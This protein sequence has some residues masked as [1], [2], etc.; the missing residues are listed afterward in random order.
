MAN[1][2]SNSAQCAYCAASYWSVHLPL[3]NSFYKTEIDMKNRLTKK[4][5]CLRHASVVRNSRAS[6]TYDISIEQ[7]GR[8][9]DSFPRFRI[10]LNR[11]PIRVAAYLSHRK[12]LDSLPLG[13]D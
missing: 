12:K 5:R 9:S 11:D 8:D 13:D 10:D 4:L 1:Q 6:V 7:W 2:E 3:S